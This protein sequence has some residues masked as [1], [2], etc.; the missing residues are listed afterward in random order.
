MKVFIAFPFFE[1]FN[2]NKPILLNIGNDAV[3]VG[4]SRYASAVVCEHRMGNGRCKGIFIP[5][6]ILT[7]T[8]LAASTSSALAP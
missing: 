4:K 8:P 3:A 5:C 1:L 6:A 2:P 7:S